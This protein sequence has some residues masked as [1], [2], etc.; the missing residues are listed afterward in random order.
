MP[1]TTDVLVKSAASYAAA[2]KYPFG[3]KSE[4]LIGLLLTSGS[5][6]GGAEVTV[7]AYRRPAVGEL[8][9]PLP[10]AEVFRSEP[11]SLKLTQKAEVP[12]T[13]TL[14]AGKVGLLAIEPRGWPHTYESN[15]AHYLGYDDPFGTD[16]IPYP[17][18]GGVNRAG[19]LSNRV[20]DGVLRYDPAAADPKQ[21]ATVTLTD[22]ESKGQSTETISIA[23][24][25]D[26]VNKIPGGILLSIR[27]T[28]ENLADNCASLL[29]T[30]GHKVDVRTASGVLHKD[31]SRL[32][33]NDTSDNPQ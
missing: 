9:D 28:A 2:R 1:S 29:F 24:F 20:F 23:A 30:G 18:L 4:A 17:A 14:A 27:V 26:D 16:E 7:F 12:F 13:L 32:V 22:V 8:D 15:R 25:D 5:F 11:P 21:R 10:M 33:L 3:S 19:G 31:L 6:T